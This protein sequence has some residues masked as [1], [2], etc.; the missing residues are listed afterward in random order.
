[1]RANCSRTVGG[2]NEVILEQP[3]VMSRSEGDMSDK[4]SLIRVDASGRQK[5]WGQRNGWRTANPCLR[6][7]SSVK[8]GSG[9]WECCLAELQGCRAKHWTGVYYL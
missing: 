4:M 1:M 8:N 3:E 7:P 9:K 6:T 2:G 5:E